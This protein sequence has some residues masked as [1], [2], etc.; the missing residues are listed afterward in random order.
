MSETP[1]MD[2]IANRLQNDG[3]NGIITGYVL[4]AEYVD[5]DGDSC[6]FMSYPDEQRLST[7][8]GHAEWL[9][10]MLRKGAKDYLDSLEMGDEGED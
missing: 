1:I 4:L 6:W 8:I 3:I 7:S 5:D 2:A 9:R 10:I